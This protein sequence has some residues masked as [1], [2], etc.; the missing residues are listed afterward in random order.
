LRA[1]YSDGGSVWPYDPALEKIC[2]ECNLIGATGLLK[3][4]LGVAQAIANGAEQFVVTTVSKVLI[5][6]EGRG[7][8]FGAEK[9]FESLPRV[10]E[11]GYKD[12]GG[13]VVRSI[14]LQGGGTAS[15]RSFSNSG[16]P[17]IQIRV[18]GVQQELKIRYD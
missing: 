5:N 11:I 16:G 1:G 13:A 14:Q 8:M 9:L 2:P 4:A 15:L 7:G 10:G 18:P 12:A 6:A 17:T 3:G